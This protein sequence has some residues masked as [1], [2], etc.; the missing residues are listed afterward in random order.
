MSW[1]TGVSDRAAIG[2]NN[3]LDLGPL[4]LSLETFE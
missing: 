2:F 3:R 1:Y 4:A